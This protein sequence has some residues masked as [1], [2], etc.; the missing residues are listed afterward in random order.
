MSL[1]TP[2]ATPVEIAA[3]LEL[4]DNLA[5]MGIEIKR[6]NRSLESSHDLSNGLRAAVTRNFKGLMF[7]ERCREESERVLCRFR[8]RQERHTADRV[9][10][11]LPKQAATATA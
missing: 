8:R 9:R 11:Y 3:A 2:K 4:L 10:T 6:R 7:V 5:A 1:Y